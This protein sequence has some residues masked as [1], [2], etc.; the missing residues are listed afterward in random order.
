MGHV[1][2]QIR[3]MTGYVP[4]AQPEGDGWVKLNQ[5]EN[6]Y[7]P[8]PLA[9]E[10]MRD[11]LDDVRI[12]PESSS[13]AVR[14]AAASVYAI[15]QDQ[16]MVANGSDEMLRILF[17]GCVGEGEE[18]VA[19][20]PSYTYYE[21]LAGI[22]GASYRLVAFTD[23][24]GLPESLN[25]DQAR[26]V[27]L[28]NPNAPSGTLFSD[29]DVARLCRSVPN[30]VVVVDEA[31]AD[32]AKSTSLPL[33][34]EMPNLVV[35]RTFSKSYS[36]AGLRLGLGFGRRE[37]MAEL[38]KVR[39]FYNVDCVAQAGGRAALQDQEHLQANVN[40][41]IA[42]RTRLVD[43]LE[44]LGLQVWPSAANFVLARFA[45]PGAALVHRALQAR[46]I[47][48]RHF[49]R[50]RLEDCLRISVGTDAEIDSLLGALQEILRG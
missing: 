8:S 20:Y 47:L 11:A 27:F 34:Q 37:L 3:Q 35:T 18:V 7:P 10:A 17:Q 23:D 21:T 2:N 24:Y 45:K 46:K 41:I 1:R 4:G 19:F 9:L 13:E 30:G 12:Y 48:V 38:D 25:L 40:R 31:Y 43:A 15:P 14:R 16:I 49:P 6:P 33:L 44:D 32:F 28:P 22:Q 39:D 36:L 29:G 50:P 26:L 42:T 5:N